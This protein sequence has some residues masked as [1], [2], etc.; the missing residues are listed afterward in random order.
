[1][2]W[3]VTISGRAPARRAHH[4]GKPVVGVDEVEPL[5]PQQR[6]QPAGRRQVLAAAGREGEDVDLD[7]ALSHLV[8]LVP[9]PPAPLRR[10]VVG[11]EVGDDE[12]AHP[13]QGIYARSFGMTVFLIVRR[14][15]AGSVTTALNA[16][17]SLR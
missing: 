7:A 13:G 14:L 16:R 2:P 11:H 8:D 4:P 6:P 5:P 17:E 10:R 3:K 12:D 1:M 9:H 15:P